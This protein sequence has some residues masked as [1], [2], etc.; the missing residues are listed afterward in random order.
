MAMID[1]DGLLNTISPSLNPKPL[2]TSNLITNTLNINAEIK[3]KNIA[4][5]DVLGK[6]LAVRSLSENAFDVSHL[7]HGMYFINVIGTNGKTH[8]SKFI[9]D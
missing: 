8:F 9:K 1:V 3:V 4:F 6:K 2:L 5:F 7:S